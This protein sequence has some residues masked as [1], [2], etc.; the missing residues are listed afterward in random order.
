MKINHLIFLLLL[1]SPAHGQ[2]MIFC[3]PGE[4]EAEQSSATTKSKT[5]PKEKRS[6]ASTLEA[7]NSFIQ[8]GAYK[9]IKNA[10]NKLQYFESQGIQV[11][12]TQHPSNKSLF[13]VVTEKLSSEEI[14]QLSLHL[15]SLSVKHLVVKEAIHRSISSVGE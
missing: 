5:P 9:D 7:S 3:D 8:L 2:D 14:R 15:K 6:N 11:K 10:G 12:I 13:R 1:V 4:F